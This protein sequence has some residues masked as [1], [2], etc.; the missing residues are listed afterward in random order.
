MKPY[1]SPHA[2]EAA[3][4]PSRRATFARQSRIHHG[5]LNLFSQG[6]DRQLEAVHE[7]AS[8]KQVAASR[9]AKLHSGH[10]YHNCESRE[11]REFPSAG[12]R[13][14]P[15]AEHKEAPQG[16]RHVCNAPA[17]KQS[18]QVV[19]ITAAYKD[20]L[21]MEAPRPSVRVLPD[22]HTSADV[23]DSLKYSGAAYD[24]QLRGEMAMTPVGKAKS[25]GPKRILNY[26]RQESF[27]QAVR[28]HAQ[29]RSKGVTEFYVQLCRGTIGGVTTSSTSTTEARLWS[30]D[31]EPD[32]R[33]LTLASCREQLVSLTGIPVSLLELAD[34]LWE[35]QPYKERALAHAGSSDEAEE[36]RQQADLGSLPI[37]YKDFSEAFGENST[38]TRLA[39]KKI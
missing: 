4:M 33:I 15:L 17:A 34:L 24:R 19:N 38:N 32:H 27:C 16:I 14:V 2:E 22:R 39:V 30:L 3:F 12:I 7:E 8:P 5:T 13:R 37:R 6:D 1:I 36:E 29:Q 23:R 10:W 26:T 28:D 21:K 11:T 31:Q 25:T 18:I 35:M 20:P 9:Y